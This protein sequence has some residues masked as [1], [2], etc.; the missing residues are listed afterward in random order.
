[1][2]NVVDRRLPEAAV[3]TTL[4]IIHS[5]DVFGLLSF[6][7]LNDEVE[8]AVE[9]EEGQAGVLKEQIGT[10]KTT[11]EVLQTIYS[12]DA[13]TNII[14]SA[15]FPRRLNP[16]KKERNRGIVCLSTQFCSD[17]TY[18]TLPASGRRV[19]VAVI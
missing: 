15:G 9:G 17:G 13:R 1:M 14:T 6:P 5:L 12:V 18:L 16:G 7:W 19:H 10:I 8:V 3:L 4:C 2:S 11:A